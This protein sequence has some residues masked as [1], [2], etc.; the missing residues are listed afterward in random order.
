MIAG[1]EAELGR[2]VSDLLKRERL[3]APEAKTT[4][5]ST[6]R[7]LAVLV[8]GVLASQADT[9]EKLTGPRGRLPSRTARRRRPR[10]PLRRRPAWPL[11]SS[12]RLPRQGRI[13]RRDGEAHGPHR[14]RVSCGRVAEGSSGN[15][16]G[17]EHVLAR[18]QAG[19]VCA[20]GALGRRA[21][22]LGGR[23]AG[24]C[25]HRRRQCEPRASR[26]AWR[27]AGHDCIR[28][29]IRRGAARGVS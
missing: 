13:C 25:R 28:Q 22:G 23:S 20:A 15:L 8:E 18:G 1:A 27:G 24:D 21:D 29:R 9:E 5:Y 7:R 6:P 26:A 14:Q 3:L 17:Q 10:R 16:L 12:K 4:T 19:A 11:M 2:R